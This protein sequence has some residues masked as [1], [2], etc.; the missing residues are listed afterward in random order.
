M[1]FPIT[2][3]FSTTFHNTTKLNTSLLNGKQKKEIDFK[4]FLCSALSFC[5]VFFLSQLFF[6]AFQNSSIVLCVSKK[7]SF[8]CSLFFLATVHHGT[9]SATETFAERWFSKKVYTTYFCCIFV[10]LLLLVLLS[11]EVSTKQN[12]NNK[13]YL[14]I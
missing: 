8:L 7:Q 4:N 6:T 1:N 12:N 14:H 9:L 5:F 13:I 2:K 3:K 10:F 11:L